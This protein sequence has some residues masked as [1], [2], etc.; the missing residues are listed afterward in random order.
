MNERRW[1]LNF[2]W[3]FFQFLTLCLWRLI[4]SVRALVA[5]PHLLACPGAQDGGSQ[6]YCK[7]VGNISFVPSEISVDLSES[8]V[9]V[10]AVRRGGAFGSIQASFN[11][12]GSD[13][14]DR[15]FF[16][17][18]GAIVWG[19]YDVSPKAIS[20]ILKSSANSSTYSITFSVEI[21]VI[22]PSAL[23]ALTVPD[24]VVTLVD[25]RVS[26]GVINFVNPQ[27]ILVPSDT[28]GS[29]Q[30]LVSRSGGSGCNASVL[31]MTSPIPG[32]DYGQYGG[33]QRNYGK[34]FWPQGDESDQ[35]LTMQIIPDSGLQSRTEGFYLEL[36]DP[37]CARLAPNYHHLAVTISNHNLPGVIELG[38]LNLVVDS[39]RVSVSVSIPVNRVDGTAGTVS[40]EYSTVPRSARSGV[41]FVQTAGILIWSPSNGNTQY[42]S[43]TI[44]P[45]SS[46]DSAPQTQFL[47]DLTFVAGTT[48]QGQKFATVTIQNTLLSF[49]LLGFQ[50]ELPCEDPAPP[51][52]CFYVIEGSNRDAV[53][54]VLRR[55]GEQ[56][57]VS[58]GYHIQAGQGDMGRFF[59][60]GNNTGT[61]SWANL[62]T[63]PKTI[64]LPL[65]QLRSVRNDSF[66]MVRI[67]LFNPDTTQRSF[68]DPEWNMINVIFVA[69][70]SGGFFSVSC[71]NVSLFQSEQG[72]AYFAVRR[73][74][75][76]VG[77]ATVLFETVSGSMSVNEINCDGAD[78]NDCYGFSSIFPGQ[79][80]NLT[81]YPYLNAVPRQDF[82][83]ISGNVTWESGDNSDKIIQVQILNTYVYSFQNYFKYFSF[84]LISA[85]GSN[86]HNFSIDENR[87]EA[88]AC[89]SNDNAQ[90]GYLLFAN[91]SYD[92][93]AKIILNAPATYLVREANQTLK[94]GVMR[95]AGIAGNISLDY[96]TLQLSED[97]SG[98][99]CPAIAGKH[100]VN[101]EGRLEWYEGDQSDKFIA[102]KILSDPVWNV[103]VVYRT[104]QVVLENITLFSGRHTARTYSGPQN[105]YANVTIEESDGP[106]MAVFDAV[107]ISVREDV[108]N[109][110]V[111][112]NRIGGRKVKLGAIFSTQDGSAQAA[113]LNS[114]GLPQSFPVDCRN[115]KQ[116]GVIRVSSAAG[117]REI[118][119]D[120]SDGVGSASIFLWDQ[121]KTTLWDRQC[122]I[123]AGTGG[124]MLSQDFSVDLSRG[125]EFGS[126]SIQNWRD[127]LSFP[128]VGSFLAQ[129][130]RDI[131][132]YARPVAFPLNNRTVWFDW[133]HRCVV[134]YDHVN[135]YN[136]S[137]DDLEIDGNGGM[138]DTKN[139][140]YFISDGI[141]TV[142]LGCINI[143]SNIDPSGYI[144]NSN[145]I[146][147]VYGP[148]ENSAYLD[149]GDWTVLVNENQDDA[150]VLIPD[151]GFDFF[152]MGVNF[153]STIY[154]GSNGYITF[155]SG[156]TEYSNLSL[157]NPSFPSI[158]FGS[159][160]NSWQLV[161]IRTVD[162]AGIKACVVRYEGTASMSGV[163]SR[164][165]IVAEISL[166][167]DGRIRIV[168]DQHAKA[169]QSFFAI[170]DGKGHLLAPCAYL[171]NQTFTFR[172]QRPQ[173]SGDSTVLQFNWGSG[174]VTHEKATPLTIDVGSLCRLQGGS[175][176]H[177]LWT[178]N[179]RVMY[180]DCTLRS[181]PS[182]LH[183][184]LGGTIRRPNAKQEPFAFSKCP[185]SFFG[186][187]KNWAL[188]S[189]QS[190]SGLTLFSMV[191][192]A[193]F[194]YFGEIS[195]SF[196]GGLF[197]CGPQQFGMTRTSIELGLLASNDYSPLS[198]TLFWNAGD[199]SSK[200][201]NITI[202]NDGFVDHQVIESFFVVL[203][204]SLGSYAA[205]GLNVATVSILD[206]NGPGLVSVSVNPNF[207]PPVAE[208]GYCCQQCSDVQ[209][210][211]AQFCT[212]WVVSR[213]SSRGA[214]CVDVSSV[215]N[216]S[217]VPELNAI[218]FQHYIPI[219]E[220]IC[221]DHQEM[222]SKQVFVF[223]APNHGYDTLYKSF[224]L[225]ASS[226][227]SPYLQTAGVN[228]SNYW[229][230]L[231]SAAVSAIPYYRNLT[232]SNICFGAIIN[233]PAYLTIYDMDAQ[234]GLISF[235]ADL[236]TGNSIF[237]VTYD[238]HSASLLVQRVYGHD[239]DLAVQYSTGPMPSSLRNGNGSSSIPIAITALDGSNGC[240]I[241]CTASEALSG[242][243]FESSSNLQCDV[244]SGVC[245]FLLTVDVQ[246]ATGGDSDG[247]NATLQESA[248]DPS[249]FL[250]WTGILEWK[251]GDQTPR[252]IS[253]PVFH[254]NHAISSTIPY[255]LYRA[256]SVNL[257]NLASSMV[258]DGTRTVLNKTLPLPQSRFYDE[259]HSCPQ[260]DELSQSY[261]MQAAGFCVGLICPCQ[262]LRCRNT[263]TS[264]ALV[265]LPT[266]YSVGG[267]FRLVNTTYFLPEN[268]SS[269]HVRIFV[270]RVG[271]ALGSVSVEFESYGY[272][273]SNF[274]VAAKVSEVHFQ[275]GTLAWN[276]S[277]IADKEILVPI[278]NDRTYIDGRLLRSFQI[279]LINAWPVGLTYIETG[280][281]VIT[282]IIVDDDAEVGTVVFSSSL[283]SVDEFAGSINLGVARVGGFDGDFYV[284][285]STSKAQFW[286]SISEQMGQSDAFSSYLVDQ[287]YACYSMMEG[288]PT[289]SMSFVEAA[290]DFN[291]DTA[292]DSDVVAG[293]VQWIAYTF[294]N[295]RLAGNILSSY[296]F[297]T[298][299]GGSCPKHWIFEASTDNFI[300]ESLQNIVN[301]MCTPYGHPYNVFPENQTS[302]NFLSYRWTFISDTTGGNR[303]VLSEV[304]LS[305]QTGTSNM[306]SA[307]MCNRSGDCCAFQGGKCDPLDGHTFMLR[308]TF[309]DYE[310]KVELL[311][312]LDGEG[313]VKNF[314]VPVKRDHL[315]CTEKTCSL[316]NQFSDR[317]DEYFAVTISYPLAV[318]ALG[319]E[320]PW[321]EPLSL[322]KAS[323]PYLKLPN[324]DNISSTVRII[325][326]DGPGVL[327]ILCVTC[328]NRGGYSVQKFVSRAGLIEGG[329][330]ADCPVLETANLV[331]FMVTRSG[332]GRGSVSVDFVVK[333]ESD[334][335]NPRADFVSGNGSVFWTH[336]DTSSK[337]FSILLKPYQFSE[338][339]VNSFARPFKVELKNPSGGASICPCERSVDEK[340]V[341]PGKSSVVVNILDVN[342]NPGRIKILNSEL[343]ESDQ[344][345]VDIAQGNI[346]ISVLRVGGSDLPL[347]IFYSTEV[348]TNSSDGIP[349]V[350]CTSEFANDNC[351]YWPTHGKLIWE[352]GSN[353]TQNVSVRLNPLSNLV[354]FNATFRFR[355]WGFLRESIPFCGGYDGEVPHSNYVNLLCDVGFNDV[356]T[357]LVSARPGGH[358]GFIS[359]LWPYA[360]IEGQ[361]IKLAVLRT[362]SFSGLAFVK[363]QTYGGSALP[364][365]NYLSAETQLSWV[366][367]DSSAQTVVIPTYQILPANT[368]V[369]LYVRLVVASPNSII[370]PEQQEVH[371]TIHGQSASYTAQFTS[372][373]VS[374]STLAISELNTIS[375]QFGINAFVGPTATLVITG[376]KDTETPSSSALKVYGESAAIFGNVS[377]W[378]ASLGILNFTVLD[379][380]ALDPDGVYRLDVKLKNPSSSL[381]GKQIGMKLEVVPVC[382]NQL[383]DSGLSCPESIS[384]NS[385]GSLSLSITQ[386]S[387]LQASSESF[388]VRTV[389]SHLCE[390][391]DCPHAPFLGA[392]N[393]LFLSL[394]PTVTI[395]PLSSF[396][397]SGMIGS[398][399]PSGNVSVRI[400]NVLSSSTP[401]AKNISAICSC[402]W[403]DCGCSHTFSGIPKVTSA[404]LQIQVQC[405]YLGR[406]LQAFGDQALIVRI[407]YNKTYTHSTGLSFDPGCCD[408][409]SQS[410]S[411]FNPPLRVDG[412]ISDA[413]L[414]FVSISTLSKL[415]FC[416]QSEFFHAD[417]T[418]SWVTESS[419]I[420]ELNAFWNEITGMLIFSL[421]QHYSMSSSQLALMAFSLNNPLVENS[422]SV[423]TLLAKS[424]DLTKIFGP[425]IAEGYVLIADR[426]PQLRFAGVDFFPNAEGDSDFLQFKLM[427]NGPVGGLVN[428]MWISI[429]GLNGSE[430]SDNG[431]IP[432]LQCA[433][434]DTQDTLSPEIPISHLIGDTSVGTFGKGNW[435]QSE[436]RLEFLLRGV[437]PLFLIPEGL[438]VGGV[439]LQSKRMK[440]YDKI[441][442]NIS[443]SVTGEPVLGAPYVPP[444]PM[445][446]GGCGI[447]KQLFANKAKGDFFFNAQLNFSDPTAFMP[448]DF[449]NISF[450]VLQALQPLDVITI[451]TPA[452][453][454]CSSLCFKGNCSNKQDSCSNIGP[455]LLPTNVT[456]PGSSISPV[457]GNPNS[458]FLFHWNEL[459]KELKLTLHYGRA[460]QNG[461]EVQVLIHPND[462]SC[463]SFE[464]ALKLVPDSSI[465]AS[466]VSQISVDVNYCPP[467]ND[468]CNATAASVLTEHVVGR[469]GSHW[470]Q[471]SVFLNESEKISGRVWFAAQV[472]SGSVYLLGGIAFSGFENSIIKTSDGLTWSRSESSIP[473]SQGRA[474]FPSTSF[475]GFLWIFGGRGESSNADLND[476]WKSL[477]G[478]LWCPVT[479]RAGWAPRRDHAAIEHSGLLWILGGV[480]D[481]K[482]KN[483]V[484]FSPD[485]V[486]WSLA[487]SR[488][489]FS[490]RRRFSAVSFKSRMW[491]YG[492]SLTSSGL[493]FSFDGRNWSQISNSSPWSARYLH[494]G[495]VFQNRFWIIGN[496]MNTSV[497]DVWSSVDGVSWEEATRW[498]A[499]GSRVGY[500]TVVFQNRMWII[501]GATEE[502][503]DLNLTSCSFAAPS[504][505]CQKL[506]YV[507]FYA[508]N[509]CRLSDLW[510][511]TFT[512][513]NFLTLQVSGTSDVFGAENRLD[514]TASL[515]CDLD[516]GSNL[517]I[518]GLDSYDRTELGPEIRITGLSSYYFDNVGYWRNFTLAGSV[519]L[520]IREKIPA[521]SEINFSLI[522]QNLDL[523]ETMR[524]LSFTASSNLFDPFDVYPWAYQ[525]NL[526]AARTNVTISTTQLISQAEQ[527]FA[528]IFI[529]V[530]LGRDAGTE[531]SLTSSDSAN[532]SVAWP[533][534]LDSASAEFYRSALNYS[535]VLQN[536]FPGTTFSLKSFCRG[537]SCF[538]CNY[539][540]TYLQ[541]GP[542]CWLDSQDFAMDDDLGFSMTIAALGVNDKK[543]GEAILSNDDCYLEAGLSEVNFNISTNALEY[544]STYV[545]TCPDGFLSSSENF[546][547]CIEPSRI[548]D[549]GIMFDVDVTSNLFV[550]SFELEDQR[551]VSKFGIQNTISVYYKSGSFTEQRRCN[552]RNQNCSGSIY[553]LS[554]WRYLGQT[555]AEPSPSGHISFKISDLNG[556]ISEINQGW[557]TSESLFACS[558]G[559]Q[560]FTTWLGPQP[561]WA[562]N[563]DAYMSSKFDDSVNITD[564][565]IQNNLSIWHSGGEGTSDD[566]SIMESGC[567]NLPFCPQSWPY[568]KNQWLAFDLKA[569]YTLSGFRTRLPS[570][571]MSPTYKFKN[572]TRT[573][574]YF[575]NSTEK[576]DWWQRA[577]FKDFSFEF[578]N[579][580]INGPWTAALTDVGQ[581]LYT[582]WQ[583]YFFQPITARYWRLFMH[584]NFGFGYMAIGAIEFF[585]SESIWC[586]DSKWCASAVLC[587][588]Q[589][590]E[591]VTLSQSL[592]SDGGLQTNMLGLISGVH[593]FFIRSTLGSGIGNSSRS[594]GSLVSND[595]KIAIKE[596]ATFE[597]NP[598]FYA[599]QQSDGDP[600]EFINL[601]NLVENSL[602]FSS[603]VPVSLTIVLRFRAADFVHNETLLMLGDKCSNGMQ[604]Q[605]VGGFIS[606]VQGCD[607]FSKNYQI[608]SLGRILKSQTYCLSLSF[609]NTFMRWRVEKLS[610]VALST[611]VSDRLSS[612][613]SI[614]QFS[615]LIIGASTPCGLNSF[616]GVIFG[617]SLYSIE[618]NE[619][620]TQVACRRTCAETSRDGSCLETASFKLEQN[621][622]TSGASDVVYM[623]LPS[624][625]TTCYSRFR[626]L[627]PSAFGD[628]M[629]WCIQEIALF[630]SNSPYW[631]DIRTMNTRA[632]AVCSNA[633]STMCRFAF[634][635][636]IDDDQAVTAG[637]SEPFC[638]AGLGNDWISLNFGADVCI[639]GYGLLSAEN[640]TRSA[641]PSAWLVHGSNDGLTWNLIDSQY[642]AT[643]QRNSWKRFALS[644]TLQQYLFF[645][646]FYDASQTF[647][648]NTRSK[649]F[650]WTGEVGGWV[651]S[652]ELSTRGARK[653]AHFTADGKHYLAVSSVRDSTV[654]AAARTNDGRATDSQVGSDI[655]IW[656]ESRFVPV[657]TLTTNN[658]LDI[659]FFHISNTDYLI[660]ADQRKQS[661][662]ISDGID[663]MEVSESS[664]LF[665]RSKN[666]TST[667]KNQSC[668]IPLACKSCACSTMY[669]GTAN[670]SV[671]IESNHE[672]SLAFDGDSS[673][674]W[675]GIF[676][677]IFY[678][679]SLNWNFTNCNSGAYVAAYSISTTDKSCPISWELQGSND[680]LVWKVLDRQW[681]QTCRENTKSATFVL[682]PRFDQRLVT[683]SDAEPSVQP[684]R[685][686][687]VVFINPGL[688]YGFGKDGGYHETAVEISEIEFV[689]LSSSNAALIATFVPWTVS[690]Y[691]F[692]AYYPPYST[693]YHDSDGFNV[694]GLVETDF[695]YT[696]VFSTF[697]IEVI[698]SAK[699]INSSMCSFGDL[700]SPGNLW[701][702]TKS[703]FFSCTS[704]WDLCRENFAVCFD[705]ENQK[706][707][708]SDSDYNRRDRTL[709]Y[710]YKISFKTSVR[711]IYLRMRGC[712]WCGGVVSV[713]DHSG[714]VVAMR[715]NEKVTDCASCISWRLKVDAFGREFYLRE[716]NVAPISLRAAIS[717]DYEPFSEWEP[718]QMLPTKGASDVQFFSILENSFLAIANYRDYD[719]CYGE[720]ECVNPQGS[721]PPLA[722]S[723]LPYDINSTIFKFDINSP[724]EP[725]RFFQNVPTHGA[726][727]IEHFAF[728]G[729]NYLAVAN[730][731]SSLTSSPS[732][733]SAVYV[734]N[735]SESLFSLFQEIATYGARKLLQFQKDGAHFLMIANT[736]HSETSLM[737]IA[738]Y[739]WT[740]SVFVFA[741]NLPQS[742]ASSFTFFTINAASYIAIS[743]LNDFNDQTTFLTNSSIYRWQDASRFLGS[744][745]YSDAYSTSSIFFVKNVSS[746]TTVGGSVSTINVSL[747]CKSVLLAYSVITI[748][749][750]SNSLTESQLLSVFGPDA[751]VFDFLGT[752][753]REQGTLLLVL[754]TDVEPKRILVFSFDI[755]NG[756]NY[757]E[758]LRPFVSCS[759]RT[760]ILA[761]TMSGSVLGVT[762]L[763]G[764]TFTERTVSESSQ[765]QYFPENNITV[766]LKANRH[767]PSGSL[768]TLSNLSGVSHLSANVGINGPD[769]ELFQEYASWRADMIVFTVA[770]SIA[771][772]NQFSFSFSV[773]NGPQQQIPRIL[774]VNVNFAN[775]TNL[776]GLFPCNGA[777]L[778]FKDPPK[779]TTAIMQGS[780]NINGSVNT[781]FVTLQPG[782][783]LSTGATITIVGLLQPSANVGD[784]V[785]L[786]G[787]P[788]DLYKFRERKG[789]LLC[790]D[791]STVVDSLILEINETM[792]YLTPTVFSFEVQNYFD[793]TQQSVVPSV[794]IT[795][796]LTHDSPGYG[797]LSFTTS[798]EMPLQ[799]V[800]SPDGRGLALIFS[801]STNISVLNLESSQYVSSLYDITSIQ[802][803][804][805]TIEMWVMVLRTDPTNAGTIKKTILSVGKAFILGY[806]FGTEGQSYSLSFNIS[807]K[808]ITGQ[809]FHFT[810][811]WASI[812]GIMSNYVN[813]AL[814]SSSS[815]AL[816]GK[817]LLVSGR[818]FLGSAE[819]DF[820]IRIAQVR[821]WSLALADQDISWTSGK[822]SFGL[823]FLLPNFIPQALLAY[824]TFEFVGSDTSTYM[825]NLNATGLKTSK[826]FPS[827]AIRLN[828]YIYPST[829]LQNLAVVSKSKL[830]SGDNCINI[831]FSSS[832][833]IA[834]GAKLYVYGLLGAQTYNSQL[835][836]FATSW[837]SATSLFSYGLWDYMKG[838][839]ILTFENTLRSNT[840]VSIS[841][842]LIN[843][844]HDQSGQVIQVSVHD[845]LIL[846]FSDVPGVVGNSTLSGLALESN[847]KIL[848]MSCPFPDSQQAKSIWLQGT[849]VP[850]RQYESCPIY[851]ANTWGNSTLPRPCDCIP[852]CPT[853]VFKSAICTN[854]SSGY[855]RPTMQVSDTTSQ[856]GVLNTVTFKFQPDR[857]LEAGSILLINGLTGTGTEDKNASNVCLIFEDCFLQ[858]SG[859]SLMYFSNS[860]GSWSNIAGKLILE[861]QSEWT[862]LYSLEFSVQL[863]NGIDAQ[864]FITPTVEVI[865]NVLI[866]PTHI[867]GGILKISPSI[868][869]WAN[870]S[871]SNCAKCQLNT[872]NI[873][874]VANSDF[875]IGTNISI[876]GLTG[877]LTQSGPVV[878]QG[879]YAYK[880]QDNYGSA[881]TAFFDLEHSTLVLFTRYSFAAGETITFQCSVLN[882]FTEQQAVSPIITVISGEKFYS[883]F[884]NGHGLSFRG[885]NATV[886]Q[887]NFSWMS[888]GWYVNTRWLSTSMPWLQRAAGACCV[889]SCCSLQSCCSCADLLSSSD[890][891]SVSGTYFAGSACQ[892][893]CD[894]LVYISG[895]TSSA[896]GI[897][898]LSDAGSNTWNEAIAKPSS[899]IIS[900]RFNS[901]YIYAFVAQFG[902]QLEQDSSPFKGL[903]QTVSPVDACTELQDAT[904]AGNVVI[905]Q[906]GD[907]SFVEQI[908]HAQNAGAIAAI[909]YNN[910]PG[911]N[912]FVMQ[913]EGSS[914]GIPALMTSFADGL[915]L[916][917]SAGSISV[918]F[919][920]SSSFSP[921]TLVPKSRNGH[922]AFSA[923]KNLYIY[924]GQDLS[925][926]TTELCGSG[927]ILDDFWIFD[928]RSDSWNEISD[929][930]GPKER[931]GHSAAVT[932]PSV[933]TTEQTFVYGNSER[934][935]NVV[936]FGGKE[937]GGQILDDIWSFN[938]LSVIW[939]NQTLNF[940]SILKGN[941]SL[942][943][944]RRWAHAAAAFGQTVYFFGGMSVEGN[945]LNDFW[946]LTVDSSGKPTQL[947]NLTM[948]DY[949]GKCTINYLCEYPSARWGHSAAAVAVKAS[950]E[951]KM[952]S[953]NRVYAR[954][955]VF[956]YNIFMFGGIGLND[957][958]LGDLWNFNP[959]KN[960]WTRLSL[961]NSLVTPPLRWGHSAVGAA[962]KFYVLGGKGSNN[963]TLN[964]AWIFDPAVGEWENLSGVSGIGYRWGLAAAASSDF[965]QAMWSLK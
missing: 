676:P 440:N 785:A 757:A 606:L 266:F 120:L 591:T 125:I 145:G 166:F 90:T 392:Q 311:H 712:G 490:P 826:T 518:S 867:C 950:D 233:D 684:Y 765:M 320:I 551:P 341:D 348:Y 792:S 883:S 632:V 733:M 416:G 873:S 803:D 63:E 550:S 409:C 665:A 937:A 241:F 764:P 601:G 774:A 168:K 308:N 576:L 704:Y 537:G 850:D 780:N 557:C 886:N 596:G 913:G 247:F 575:T 329:Y 178:V 296:S 617:L 116:S 427:F 679:I 624:P 638:T 479:M 411:I 110:I 458:V 603:T 462:F 225:T 39:G 516:S 910:I 948:I 842:V 531:G 222:D 189:Y 769:A 629:Q 330:D 258:R 133:E 680:N 102:L 664:I 776:I 208:R 466:D 49:G 297:F 600:F 690:A 736:L 921:I 496:I 583:E 144:V 118:F 539:N 5:P 954:R 520:T 552:R 936:I 567:P 749:G 41:H 413:G 339:V 461:D 238:Q 508:P 820:G 328:A 476:V 211:E 101:T 454:T 888:T 878:L 579:A 13:K 642:S 358:F 57:V 220:T 55:G 284:R 141:N 422:G 669:F 234:V 483:D 433:V 307:A 89:I 821:I 838:L 927:V 847:S 640:L 464:C 868:V 91:T 315:G 117:V 964:D 420:L 833:S 303:V 565:L 687:R 228:G 149:L 532:L 647:S 287:S 154:I 243:C 30:V 745:V 134:W 223:L 410:Q 132:E 431:S 316:Q 121:N 597:N 828:E 650:K 728:D 807:T 42:I 609:S 743:N 379:G 528:D 298:A 318:Y 51:G 332:I 658:S 813:G 130:P 744:I 15:Y 205:S 155:G 180:R 221:W 568:N 467:S 275:N 46:S 438:L 908:L 939:M 147:V 131:G 151:I 870:F 232:L 626:F 32:L 482:E 678:N 313:G 791:T 323:I 599:W 698:S 830:P 823:R 252:G 492:G 527:P 772:Y 324:L 1:I 511:N 505:D 759:G 68:V 172:T 493:W 207:P 86:V 58:V 825:N 562:E 281:D 334:N 224:N 717:F 419:D 183:V 706:A 812:T 646:S 912:A 865:G 229:S 546:L 621:L 654:I 836:V 611:P 288:H 21:K 250:S 697:D 598:P 707:E 892:I 351:Q 783:P 261:Q 879:K 219:T 777:I 700:Y 963:E 651:L 569:C 22:S 786:N 604:V 248:S 618:Q 314:S 430:A 204:G 694:P 649:L 459:A 559:Q 737:E 123:N 277:D 543:K 64:V 182:S 862:G 566:S 831:T 824:Y 863:Q 931:C 683:G 497:R 242:R 837:S 365:V 955:E 887:V 285:L 756:I 715:N 761:Q 555:L 97:C 82:L 512:L 960:V 290:F 28:I 928:A 463:Y 235:S 331:G 291:I 574:K 129:L 385:A 393:Y 659:K 142:H 530:V 848:N 799:D 510:I 344:Y 474:F 185:S 682:S 925:S 738:L 727:D 894:R 594:R 345:P 390:Y 76:A 674:F 394:Q 781:I 721:V 165:N 840:I 60:D 613:F 199:N 299:F 500:S 628:Q 545:T 655:F 193:G 306:V 167:A 124:F 762:E 835:P 809:W 17:K 580:G 845:G 173:N 533:H 276:D 816:R 231:S 162:E 321:S 158:H 98:I 434:C 251:Q 726:L 375:F 938:P 748:G 343:P 696:G 871:E 274:S 402:T 10:W 779:F 864:D 885:N 709:K 907:C 962:G 253:I 635:G 923:Y 269:G 631:Q 890:G 156:S 453:T 484:W 859:P 246:P 944:L 417:L 54:V 730:S 855:W 771:A 739:R 437:G 435:V 645:S 608:Q 336:G 300:W 481:L 643:V 724:L 860:S 66:E 186:K 447:T 770:Q 268:I 65:S 742:V 161:L 584:N 804:E 517:L 415:D 750:M 767:I 377:G 349:A 915:S 708:S 209:S 108:Q 157:S 37:V 898:T 469:A 198:G 40:V 170:S 143:T 602:N 25:T 784:A 564:V 85:F 342:A 752:W 184:V 448:P 758:P 797:S 139:E 561:T 961:T 811:R 880:L 197:Q 119:C 929:P 122:L 14:S 943:I 263:S 956:V 414:L 713:L 444:R 136:V 673:T 292:I 163:L 94:I 404:N 387:I 861:L 909:I 273:I 636:H 192:S 667:S 279:K 50:Q 866:P 616:S 112:V 213:S 952:Q 456:I 460:I 159:A 558:P 904:A 432:I 723:P 26:A 33:T 400:V 593:S 775:G 237:T 843:N 18:S 412:L 763:L 8:F 80:C 373:E 891:F 391:S 671:Q 535:L 846:S 48:I 630:E 829:T 425:T 615:Y 302:K 578:S 905:I 16:N 146:S 367:G 668:E 378:D 918:T 312:W 259:C 623:S 190:A 364:S 81:F 202:Y 473:L 212:H 152:Y 380:Q 525:S 215:G 317:P 949:W 44:L 465:T 760:T 622:V 368:I 4:I 801:N 773:P 926:N 439:A 932:A 857:S 701:N 547:L 45:A 692:S 666:K 893:Y 817:P 942:A 267:S 12:I 633:N 686:Y 445:L 577:Q 486:L 264:S 38:Q 614:P 722:N 176:G 179:G 244:G 790:S 751:A 695:D 73:S 262:D 805:L 589:S 56:G 457:S 693:V 230:S 839:L 571:A 169:E 959:I 844:A 450:G 798:C 625:A 304:E 719:D 741:G 499:F 218:P 875:A 881:G 515:D 353:A 19:A 188:D 138:N 135:F 800:L 610:S 424:A 644:S 71:L 23:A 428:G 766:R 399:T 595:G 689:F 681:E 272:S 340:C 542:Y 327:S 216:T 354:E 256:F 83:P 405:N 768:L 429:D 782:I 556:D 107:Q 670:A 310:Y 605:I 544:F 519:I 729:N 418:L 586:Q 501:G 573:D 522:L 105:V 92:S 793:Q 718:V 455:I 337:Y 753:N 607:S 20:I 171:Q 294:P 853:A 660:S 103:S 747:A 322:A 200:I 902:I 137:F 265:V 24:A 70:N 856:P 2:H 43:V 356:V 389:S 947:E 513:A 648:Y 470:A 502:C 293:D 374:Q 634:D 874:I 346:N 61:L 164:P 359:S 309:Y 958:V 514:I 396:T 911:Q 619:S 553:N 79:S 278:V 814:V 361:S 160:D 731:F 93:L 338:Y 489:A 295:C 827:G 877:L 819:K 355:V 526:E 236:P 388:A 754:K 627:V 795:S 106:G 491:V 917:M 794:R 249:D 663:G 7:S 372:C 384:I 895:G 87:Q 536:Y 882:G 661:L 711:L 903:L 788:R 74:S 69:R 443:I 581:T 210:S 403:E 897:V 675:R 901:S 282:Q 150:Y 480:S 127:N 637:N 620:S 705:S 818:L 523:N 876:H 802:L 725:F 934:Q 503:D 755:L 702:V 592:R 822:T 703:P 383:V 446:A 35:N 922:I 541:T 498:A 6:A 889:G 852:A 946:A 366:D 475:D 477:N 371:V 507:G 538:N 360:V 115:L 858:I 177:M 376:L 240:N 203:N 920:A 916:Q 672:P 691:D 111:K 495:L 326:D 834:Q 896:S 442:L 957:E 88:I 99:S 639:T 548:F 174:V 280:F 930:L 104:F 935:G 289:G 789:L 333:Q 72:F 653:A 59:V 478:D 509:A 849:C 710:D 933:E 884:M 357:V 468:P 227:K 441:Q 941:E 362:K 100:F 347:S 914:V 11:T 34:L 590:D 506:D 78:C 398:T 919:P 195:S 47:V 67:T 656:I 77:T 175:F 36:V 572:V 75:F 395:P 126:T 27:D 534:N 796:C 900:L 732:C 540:A 181:D 869:K 471:L 140:F 652:Q 806:L 239:T 305:F 325:D 449:F 255:P 612:Y 485:G 352:D 436:G 851:K 714:V 808:Q 194:I 245:T 95:S 685:I 260:F 688:N 214:V 906:R 217:G 191:D 734:W 114:S 587:N 406:A 257:H 521:R 716:E 397:V 699:L 582:Q 951:E 96:K 426:M 350:V 452:L 588:T 109:V 254:P 283:I 585:G 226:P 810:A 9:T 563:S 924:G 270:Q 488:A 386:T 206:L 113:L 187:C 487:T 370:N 815:G 369:D 363:Y 841:F 128:V 524:K 153:R 529:T 504:S 381:P 423:L 953:V 52:N 662:D 854:A 335:L 29:I 3:W 832:M 735:N 940:F 872:M 421:P 677:N 494:S 740:G 382:N 570:L 401:Q 554:E 746:N 201:I 31:Y 472:H 53:L 720:I 84:R 899:K 560:P 319:E 196:S 965:L 778:S 407:G 451:Y 408:K 301:G 148:A 271:G 286:S 657:D 549:G 787:A 62:D 641:M 945:I